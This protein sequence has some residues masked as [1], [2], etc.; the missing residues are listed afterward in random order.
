MTTA[1]R[2]QRQIH[3]L[4]LAITLLLPFTCFAGARIKLGTIAPRGS[5]YHRVLQEMGEAWRS[6]AGPGAEFI[7]YTDGS[8]GGEAA[9]VRRMRIGQ[10]DAAMLSANG[11]RY[12]DPSATAL[13]M[14]PLAFRN[15]DEVDYVRDK[16]RPSLETKLH[17]RGY[18]VLFWAEAG[19]VQFFS[20]AAAVRPEDFRSMSIF[21]WRGDTAQIGIMKALDYRPIPL[22]TS[23]MLPGLQS[24]L[25]DVVL[26]PPTYALASQ[27]Q[28]V[29]PH[30]LQ[31][32]WVPIVGAVVI[33]RR[34]WDAMP[35][36]AQ[37]ALR[38]SALIAE[39]K[40]RERRSAQDDGAIAAMQASGLVVHEPDPGVVAEWRQFVEGIYP[41]VRGPIV[42]AEEFDQVMTAL[43]AYRAA[44]PQLRP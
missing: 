26:T 34:T 12:I 10:L 35:L 22:E 28:T 4:L 41:R 31:I 30:M 38:E 15:W 14:I 27:F 44:Q 29:A 11:L 32:N 16:I 33:S 43:R 36:T 2:T 5:V 8:Q 23:D 40:L 9:T 13:Q 19:W 3:A 18:V 1:S 17:D 24:G 7:I 39:H 21:S 37:T 20:K 25:V 42:P 6:V